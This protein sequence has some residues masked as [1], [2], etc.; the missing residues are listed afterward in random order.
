MAVSLEHPQIVWVNGPWPCGAFSDVRVFRSG[1]KSTLD[2]DEF[3][4]ADGGYIDERCISPPGSSHADHKTLAETR[5]RHEIVNKRLKQFNVLTHR[6]KHTPSLH[7]HFFTQLSTWIISY[8]R[9][10]LCLQ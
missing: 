10:S 6:F 7:V 5:A 9:Q 8:L 4:V 2:V 3:V 1:L